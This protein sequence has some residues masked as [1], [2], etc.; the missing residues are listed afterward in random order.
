M[1]EQDDSSQHRLTGVLRNLVRGVLVCL[2]LMFVIQGFEGSWSAADVVADGLL[3]A[4]IV[5]GVALSGV[6]V[7][8]FYRRG[9][10]LPPS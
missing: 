6:A 2:G 7:L 5:L 8:Y 3:V 4:A 1:P 10:D 9:R